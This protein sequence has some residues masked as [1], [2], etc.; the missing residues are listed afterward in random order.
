[1]KERK[2][3]IDV[4]KSILIFFVVLGHIQ[5]NIDDTFLKTWIYT[6]HMPAFFILS[7]ILFNYP[8]WKEKTII[9]FISRK[10]KTLIVPYLFFELIGGVLRLAIFDNNVINYKGVIWNTIAVYCNIGANWFLPTLFLA[11]IMYLLTQKYAANIKCIIFV[12]ALI[13]MFFVPTNHFVKV[14]F[15]CIVG[16][17]YIFIGDSFKT[18]FEQ[19]KK[20]K[21]HIKILLLFSVTIIVALINGKTEFYDCIYKNPIVYLVGSVAGTLLVLYVSKYL[22]G[23]AFN[24]VGSNT[25]IIMG[26]HQ[27]VTMIMTKVLSIELTSFVN[28]FIALICILIFEAILIPLINK[29]VPFLVGKNN[30]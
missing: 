24:Y 14:I 15:R 27:I 25:V 23:K 29:F 16:Y 19:N 8:K 5:L 22:H 28:S 6:F 2:E 4:A 26:T 11:E 9:Q 30:R 7:G 1:M 13:S 21:N 18:I 17:A 10:I 20:G 12:L 3:Y